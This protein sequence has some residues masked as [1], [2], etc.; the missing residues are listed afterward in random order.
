MKINF[1]GTGSSLGIP[2]IT[3][4]CAVCS[5]KD[6]RDKRLRTSVYIEVDDQKIIIDISPDFRSQVLTAGINRIDGLFITHEHRDHIGGLDDI[7][8]YNFVQQAAINLYCSDRVRKSI[9]S[10]NEYIFVQERY[11]GVP[12]LNFF[13]VDQNPFKIKDTTVIPINA[14][15]YRTADF[16][17]PVQGFRINDFT[18][19]TDIKYIADSELEKAV[20][21]KVLVLNVL[22]KEEHYS[23]LNIEEALEIVAKLNPQKTYFTHISHLLGKYEEIQK[24]LPQNVFLAY[25][26]L[27][28]DI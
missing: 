28:L 23:H 22:R 20:G 13:E 4:N 7:R 17:L 24:E 18:Y 16:E 3:C 10:S 2:V 25:D 9:E 11:P 1:L 26:G 19:L 14:V 21:T 15:H 8:A 6:F 27:I 12:E 5:S